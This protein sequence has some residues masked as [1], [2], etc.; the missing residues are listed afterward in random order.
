MLQGSIKMHVTY[1]TILG[2]THFENHKFIN[3]HEV[4]TMENVI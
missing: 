3:T 1:Y 4:C 2:N